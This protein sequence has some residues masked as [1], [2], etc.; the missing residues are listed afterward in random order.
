[1]KFLLGKLLPLYFILIRVGISLLLFQV[2]Y[3]HYTVYLLDHTN[4]ILKTPSHS[5]AIFS[6]CLLWPPDFC[7]GYP[8]A[9]GPA[10][11]FGWSGQGDQAQ[12][13][14]RNPVVCVEEAPVDGRAQVAQE[15]LRGI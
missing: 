11:P 1:M 6:L 14:R 5:F 9:P 4:D 2:L 13:P 8:L 3:P 15:I 10:V 7:L 12:D